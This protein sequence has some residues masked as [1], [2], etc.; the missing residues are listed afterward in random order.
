MKEFGVLVP[1]VTPFTKEGLVDVD[2]YRSVVNDM[3]NN[4]CKGVFVAGSTGRSA[5]LSKE[6]RVLLC[7]ATVEETKSEMITF[8]GC[9]A[10]GIDDM[11]SH[12]KGMADVGA[13]VAVVTV[14]YYFSYN[15]NEIEGIFTEFA[16][17]SPLPVLIYDMPQFT[18]V[19]LDISMMLRLADHKNIIGFK[20]SS[21]DSERFSKIMD[22]IGQRDDLYFF[23]GKEK[24][25]KSSLQR[26]ASGFVVS[27]VHIY[28]LLFCRL[29]EAYKSGETAL[30]SDLQNIIDRVFEVVVGCFDERPE[31]STLFHLLNRCLQQRG[32]C[33]NII[34]PFEKDTP[35]WI[36]EKADEALEIAQTCRKII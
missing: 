36:L 26:G 19:K 3:L 4:G 34:M 30:L 9:M 2:S 12:A 5:W 1:I 16:D 22:S 17:R 14:P 28:P 18:G 21:A 33:E 11:L 6:D 23:Q 31:I 35:S 20:D 32:I 27:F 25:L 10:G 15:Q 8:A 7:K 29:Y 13:D 24:L